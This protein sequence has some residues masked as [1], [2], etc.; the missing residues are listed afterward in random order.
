MH[1]NQSRPH[2]DW[3]TT[4]I[5]PR[6]PSIHGH[7]GAC[8]RGKEPHDEHLF[9]YSEHHSPIPLAQNEGGVCANTEDG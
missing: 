9:G 6:P 1:D 3:S 4:G 8:P 5:T 2:E 7:G